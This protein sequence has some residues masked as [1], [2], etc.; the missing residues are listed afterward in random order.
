[1]YACP[2]ALM[3]IVRARPVSLG[4]LCTEEEASEAR[5]LCVASAY[6]ALATLSLKYLLRPA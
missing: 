4:L 5:D 6:K 3:F 1:M 2:A